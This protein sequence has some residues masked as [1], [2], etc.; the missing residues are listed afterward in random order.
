MFIIH[1]PLNYFVS[2]MNK[3]SDC[4][5][6]LIKQANQNITIMT[7]SQ[8]NTY[9]SDN[10]TA[11]KNFARKLTNDVSAAEDLV[12][13]TAM[14]A[15]RAMHTFR[16][17]TSFKSWSFT[18]LKN[19]FITGYNKKKK[20]G[21][22][23]KPIEDFT[24]YIESKNTLANNALSNMRIKE[25]KDCISELSYKSR[26]PFIMHVNGYQYNEI[27]ESLNIPIGTVKSR[28]NFA[29]TK[30]KTALKARGIGAA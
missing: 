22:V 4:E 16:P 23:N 10:Y 27:S 30:L 1:I 17:G 5:V 24:N 2:F 14:K 9:Y 26:M 15:F 12:Q 3:Y 11:L 25:I 28:I 19:T 29:R 20:R 21:V 6:I 8:F 18:I 7:E 13:E